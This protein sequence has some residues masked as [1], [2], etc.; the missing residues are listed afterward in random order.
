[1]RGINV[2]GYMVQ[3]IS[4]QLPQDNHVG[5]GVI[6]VA[7]HT[8]L[9]SFLYKA[10]PRRPN[11]YSINPISAISISDT[12]IHLF[13]HFDPLCKITIS[14][15]EVTMQII[16]VV[17]FLFAAM[18]AVA[19]PIESESFGLDTRAE[20]STLIK[21]PGVSKHKHFIP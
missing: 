1:M 7:S 17:L 11:T 5:L 10:A 2:I 15:P 21:Y 6:F 9:T 3:S 19:T 4:R 20:A 14:S 8:E 13:H 16:T 12:P 18:G